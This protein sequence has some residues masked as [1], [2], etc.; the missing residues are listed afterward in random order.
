M[1]EKVTVENIKASKAFKFARKKAKDVAGDDKKL[2]NLLDATLG[3]LEEV[4]GN[5]DKIES[6][7][8]QVQTFIRMISAYRKGTYRGI[9]VKSV[10]IIVAALLYFIMPIDL[11]PDFIPV[12]GL[13][14]DFTI[15]MYVFKKLNE[16]IDEFKTWEKKHA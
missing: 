13:L 7:M 6:F 9:N 16:E 10:V 8:S 14:D 12:V 15:V 11:I 4:T 2:G 1:A 3:K 5:G